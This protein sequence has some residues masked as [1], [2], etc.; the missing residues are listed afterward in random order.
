MLDIDLMIKNSLKGGNKTEVNA[1]RNLKSKILI[2]KTAKNAKP[3]DDTIEIS[4][5]SKYVKEL[6]EDSKS[7]FT[8]GREDLGKDYLDEANVLSKLLPKAVSVEEIEYAIWDFIETNNGP[9][10]EN[11]TIAKNQMGACIKYIKSKYPTADGKIIS[12]LVKKFIA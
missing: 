1:Y 6:N 5:I 11:K 8:A 4:I 3:Y 12:E 9:I 7:Y 2:A 10:P